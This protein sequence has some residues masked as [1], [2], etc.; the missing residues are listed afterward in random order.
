MKQNAVTGSRSVSAGEAGVCA[1]ASNG[2]EEQAG[3]RPETTVLF[4][5]HSAPDPTG[6][7]GNHRT[8]QI[9]HDLQAAVGTRNVVVV[10]S[11]AWRK[12]CVDGGASAPPIRKRLKNRL[13]RYAENPLRAIRLTGFATRGCLNHEFVPRYEALAESVRKPAVA[14]IGHPDFAELTAINRRLGIP[15]IGCP[16]NLES[17]AVLAPGAFAGR[18]GQEP[19]FDALGRGIDGLSIVADLAAEL[20]ALGELDA[21]LMI[22]QVE[23]GFVGGIGLP[24]DYYP[25][26]PVGRVREG[27]DAI[28]QRRTK[29]TVESGLLLMIGSALYGPIRASLQWLLTEVQ[30]SGLPDGTR[31]IVAG[32]QTERL[33]PP[34]VMIPGVELRGRLSQP[35]LDDVLARASCGLVPQIRGFGALTRLP[36]FACAGIPVVTSAHPLHAM[37]LTPGVGVA[38]ASCDSW[39]TAIVAALSRGGNV[40]WSEYLAW[41]ARQS[42]PITPT[43]QQLAGARPC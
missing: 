17:L 2:V 12:E 13:E 16:Q 41:E 39:C 36:E 25:Y 1:N 6:N 11:E 24:C 28:R 30:A 7:G 29:A 42:R 19:L 14:V 37:D 3:I 21:R 4:V 18:P 26:L 8:Y 9:L 31:L 40:P 35:E 22:S 10:S 32:E 15:T 27:L 38:G 34:G 5:T 20:R 23:A 33:L 43:L